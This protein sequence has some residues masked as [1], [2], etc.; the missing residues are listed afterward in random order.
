MLGSNR[1][2]WFCVLLLGVG[3]GCGDAPTQPGFPQQQPS[4]LPTPQPTARPTPPS[5]ASP[6]PTSERP[7]PQPTRTPAPTMTPVPVVDLNG[8][9]TG[10][11]AF[12]SDCYGNCRSRETI[13]VTI[14]QAGDTVTGRFSTACLGDREL[15]G[16]LRGNQLTIDFAPMSGV[17]PFEGTATSTS[18]HVEKN[19]DP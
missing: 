15:V 1:I 9:W 3:L 12:P 18:I 17:G 13:Q 11:I 2:A 16:T 7:A 19:C 5:T 6:R 8:T 4:P 10:Q 14:S